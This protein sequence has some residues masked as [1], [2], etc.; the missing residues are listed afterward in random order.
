MSDT[1]VHVSS[2]DNIDLIGTLSVTDHHK[3]IQDHYAVHGLLWRQNTKS[4]V[5]P[6][7]SHSLPRFLPVSLLVEEQLAGQTIEYIVSIK[8]NFTVQVKHSVF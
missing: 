3:Y 6:S 2:S 1:Q 4:P 7:A 5:V 8:S